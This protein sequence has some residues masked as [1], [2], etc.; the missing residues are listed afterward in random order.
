M[1]RNAPRIH[2]AE[3]EIQAL[4][5]LIVQLPEGRQVELTLDDGSRVLGIVAVQ[6][7][8]QM[9]FDGDGRQ[10]SNSLLRLDDIDTP[11]QQHRV[12]LDTVVGLRELPRQA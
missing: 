8:L 12:W 7:T 10:G 4:T 2:T 9:F 11:V 1:S 5:S 6:P 3:A